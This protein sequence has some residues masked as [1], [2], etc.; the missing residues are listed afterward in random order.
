MG[1][2]PTDPFRD[3]CV[4]HGSELCCKRKSFVQV[5]S[6]RLSK[7]KEILAGH[8]FPNNVTH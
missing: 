5:S 2:R 7:S 8:S 3:F 4:T 1:E 6:V